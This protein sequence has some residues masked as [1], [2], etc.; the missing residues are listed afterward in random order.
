MF[1]L[2][3]LRSARRLLA[4]IFGNKRE[5]PQIPGPLNSNRNAPLML[6]A[7]AGNTARQN[8][9]PLRHNAPQCFMGFII[10]LRFACTKNAYFSGSPASQF[11][12]VSTSSA[13]SASLSSSS[14]FHYSSSPFSVACCSSA[15]G[16]STTAGFSARGCLAGFSFSSPLDSLSRL[17]LRG[18]STTSAAS[19]FGLRRTVI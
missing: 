18:S 11:R 9:A 4:D 19:A 13:A 7:H 1:T 14:L 17:S 6:R 2:Q 15:A 10:R 12:P 16:S 5:K 3:M 8:F